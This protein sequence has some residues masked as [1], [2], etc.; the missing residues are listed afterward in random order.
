MLYYGIRPIE[1]V[2]DG[3]PAAASNCYYIQGHLVEGVR[4]QQGVSVTRLLSSDPNDYLTP[5]LSPGS[6]LGGGG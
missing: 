3:T 2:F 5:E 6:V 4:T 1:E